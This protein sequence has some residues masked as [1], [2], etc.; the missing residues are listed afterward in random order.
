[1]TPL[2]PWGSLVAASVIFGCGHL[3]N[4]F[5]FAVATFSGAFFGLLYMQTGNLLVPLIAHTL[6]DAIIILFVHLEVADL[7]SEEQ[8]EIMAEENEAMPQS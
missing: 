8:Q 3:L 2:G 6:Y 1:M 4:P 7:S 5:Y